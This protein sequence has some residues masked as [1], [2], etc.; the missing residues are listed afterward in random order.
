MK[1]PIRTLT[2]LSLAIAFSNIAHATESEF[3]MPKFTMFSSL[4]AVSIEDKDFDPEAFELELGLKGLVKIDNFKMVYILNADVSDAINSK[5]TGGNDGEADIHIIDAKVV[6]PTQYGTFAIAPRT[7]SGQLRDLYSNINIF[8]YNETHSGSAAPTGMSM[9]N[10]APE[11]QDVLAYI[12]PAFNNIKVTVA[13]I[14]IPEDNGVDSDVIALRALYDDKKLNIGFGVA[15]ADQALGG[16]A[17][18]DYK[19]YAI[20]AGYKFDHLNIGATYEINK[21]TFGSAGDFD[22]YGIT[23]RYYLDNNWSMAA[24][25]Y[26]KDSDIDANDNNGVVIQL[27]K[28]LSQHVAAWLEAADYDVTP[29]NVAAGINIKF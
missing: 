19:R 1:H 11:A 17:T 28:E 25:Y 6:L 23:G 4:G 9:F 26:N 18:K 7:A 15:Q 12:T 16:T 14:S 20:T 3:P 5:D 21:D 2:T 24:G 22:S 10:Q 13:S 27:K 29:D 8:E